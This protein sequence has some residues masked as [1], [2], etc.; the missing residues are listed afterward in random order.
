MFSGLL[1]TKLIPF[2]DCLLLAWAVATATTGRFKTDAGNL[3]IDSAVSP[4]PDAH[5]RLLSRCRRLHGLHHR[6]AGQAD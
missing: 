4:R 3:S 6:S 1:G 5:R 2:V